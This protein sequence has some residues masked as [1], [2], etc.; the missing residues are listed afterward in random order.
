MQVILYMLEE[1][2]VADCVRQTELHRGYEDG[3]LD[4]HARGDR[5]EHICGC[6][7]SVAPGRQTRGQPEQHASYYN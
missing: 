2:G 6:V 7:A 5:L 3:R 4:A 1:R